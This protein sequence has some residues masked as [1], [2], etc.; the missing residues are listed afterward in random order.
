ML[1]AAF[2]LFQQC[3]GVITRKCV[4]SCSSF[5]SSSLQSVDVG[6]A[7]TQVLRLRP[8][9]PGGIAVSGARRL[10]AVVRGI[11]SSIH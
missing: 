5:S 7:L 8:F 1:V 4:A 6:P 2:L 9:K 10:A 3:Q 11:Y